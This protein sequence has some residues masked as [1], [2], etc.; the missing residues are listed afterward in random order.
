MITIPSQT[1]LV[2]TYQG[3]TSGIGDMR[4]TMTEEFWPKVA[5]FLGLQR[6]DAPN[7]MIWA[8]GMDGKEEQ[9]L[10]EFWTPIRLYSISP[11]Q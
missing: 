3:P 2:L 8:P 7:I 10:L 1:Y 9:T 11:R 4:F 6:V 5:P